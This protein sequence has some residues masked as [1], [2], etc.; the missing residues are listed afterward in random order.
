MTRKEFIEY[1]GWDVE[2]FKN[3]IKG[4]WN[5]TYCE[6]LEYPISVYELVGDWKFRDLNIEYNKR[7]REDDSIGSLYD[8]L[9]VNATD[10]DVKNYLRK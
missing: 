3:F 6:H 10:E 4:F 7:Y 1:K 5:E 2:T 9:E 8:W